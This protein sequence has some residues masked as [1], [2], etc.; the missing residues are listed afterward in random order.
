MSDSLLFHNLDLVT[1]SHAVNDLV[2]LFGGV[3]LATESHLSLLPPPLALFF[4]DSLFGREKFS[5]THHRLF[6][7]IAST[8]GAVAIPFTGIHT[9]PRTRVMTPGTAQHRRSNFNRNFEVSLHSHANDGRVPTLAGVTGSSLLM[10]RPSSSFFYLVVFVCFFLRRVAHIDRVRRHNVGPVLIKHQR[11]SGR[12]LGR[13]R[14]SKEREK[15][16]FLSMAQS[17]ERRL[18]RKE[19]KAAGK[20]SDVA[21]PYERRRWRL[22]DETSLTPI[23]LGGKNLCTFLLNLQMFIWGIWVLH[24]NAAGQASYP[25][26]FCI[27]GWPVES[28]NRAK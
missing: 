26:P 18:Q 8:Q 23:F 3:R 17:R 11:D 20:V 13:S 21:R 15:E 7:R 5:T 2:Q 19:T 1:S 27:I 14:V 28:R 16:S 10:Q 12:F 4:H 22:P 6:C 24:P 9:P 25:S